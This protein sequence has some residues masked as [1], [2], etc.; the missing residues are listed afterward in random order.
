MGRAEIM[1]GAAVGTIGGTYLGNPVCCAAAIANIRYMKEIDINKKANHVGDIIRGRF[2]EM[3]KKHAI[4]GEVRGVGAMM[5][6]ALVKDGNPWEP[7]VELC[8]KLIS[9]CSE[10]GLILLSAGT[11]KNII[12][13][14][15][16]LTISDELLNKGL[17]IL[18][19]ELTKLTQP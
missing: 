9:A 15:S 1:D 10:R 7:E 8:Q 2:N 14:L 16:P 18:D 13:I 11:Y 17:D 12:R 6:I 3:Q 4:I 19:E 5:A